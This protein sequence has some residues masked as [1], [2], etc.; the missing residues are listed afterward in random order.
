MSHARVGGRRVEPR[1]VRR[2]GTGG[3]GQRVV[4]FQNHSLRAVLAVLTFVLF[5]HEPERVEDVRRVVAVDAV[6]V[7][8]R[9]VEFTTDQRAAVGIPPE[10]WAIVAAVVGKRFQVSS[11]VGQLQHARH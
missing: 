5:A 7:E 2:A 11:G 6:Q 1:L 9:R 10:R 4:D 3:L 8:E